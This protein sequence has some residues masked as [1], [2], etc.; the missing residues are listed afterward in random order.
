[1]TVSNDHHKIDI[2]GKLYEVK[3]STQENVKEDQHQPM[4]VNDKASR[5]MIFIQW[6]RTKLH[7]FEIHGGSKDQQEK[8]EQQLCE[9]ATK[10]DWKAAEDMEKEHKGILS[11]VISKDREETALHIATRFNQAAFVE[12]LVQKL[13]KD[14]LEATNIYGNTAL[15]IAATSGAVDIAK[16]MVQKH[17]DLVLIPGSGNATPVLIAA[18]YKHNHMVSYFLQ[19]EWILKHMEINQQMELLFSAIAT[20]H[21][22]IALLILKWNEKLAL[23]RDINDDTPLHIMAR[24]SNT[25]GTKNNLTE[26]QSCFKPIYKKKMM[27][28][29]A[30]QTLEKMWGIVQNKID[31]DKISDFILH[32][33][34]MLHDAARV[35]N[36]EFVR[37]LLHKNPKLL[38]MV[39]GSGKNI[40]HIAVE[41]RQRSVFNLI[42]DMK[43]FHLDDLLYHF[44]EE[45]ISL[46]ELAAKRADP[47]HLDRVSGAVFQM[48]QELLWFKD[49][50]NILER[51]MRIKKGKR[52]TRELFIQEHKE[53]V[54][55]AEKWVKSTA[56]S[57]MLVATLIATVVFAAAFTVPGGND[58]N[59][60]SPMF[61]SHKW[62]TVF[63]VSDA[64]AL[65]SSS[66][67]ILLF[68]SILTSRCA[69]TDF[70]F[71]LPLEL[72]LGLG[73]LFV[74]V[75]GMV[76]A[77]SACF[78]LHYG[79]H[80]SCIPLL[81]TGMA[82][83]PVY[84]FCVLQ[85]KL[86]ADALAALHASG[87]SCLL[88]CR[89]NKWF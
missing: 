67:S 2:D 82:I 14:D 20:D 73:F 7:N 31:E 48:H 36:V 22:D 46:L 16:F 40:F 42:Y 25:I 1:M 61:L 83:V 47:G 53:L 80:I 44:N 71:W 19:M 18:R 55:E 49:V 85:W 27:Q 75:L 4:I 66:T 77:F 6:A 70:L 23:D 65:I 3:W 32:P 63:V 45:N 26:W 43:L 58:E 78:F 17:N 88:K 81:I 24:K 9:A 38:L 64:I 13:T 41:N 11:K 86:W 10:G 50:E 60:G 15:C 69:E 52:T 56:N 62:F 12:K 84:W 57:C 30:Y 37:V 51:T 79:S 8:Q 28:I 21:Y 74:S 5:L 89:Q 35:G 59:N 39:D 34:S 76:L 54:K 33:S 68:L 29:Q 87:M 72:V